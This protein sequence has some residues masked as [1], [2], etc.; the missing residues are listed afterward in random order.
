MA[1]ETTEPIAFQGEIRICLCG[2]QA[3]LQFRQ[4]AGVGFMVFECPRELA[5]SPDLPMYSRI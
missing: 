4:K 2:R 5:G 1:A 3:Q